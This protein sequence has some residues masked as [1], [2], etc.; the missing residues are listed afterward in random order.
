MGRS[1]GLEQLLG[2]LLLPAVLAAT[3]SNTSPEPG[4]GRE[5]RGGPRGASETFVIAQGGHETGLPDLFGTETELGLSDETQVE[6]EPTASPPPAYVQKEVAKN[7]TA[8]ISDLDKERA[9]LHERRVRRKHKQS[10]ITATIAA[11]LKQMSA[12]EKNAN[13]TAAGENKKLEEEPLTTQNDTNTSKVNASDDKNPTAEDV[14]DKEK[15]KESKEQ[16]KE[17]PEE[18]PLSTQNDTNTDNSKD[19]DAEASS[20]TV[21]PTDTPSYGSV[22]WQNLQPK[23]SDI[24]DRMIASRMKQIAAFNPWKHKTLKVNVAPDEDGPQTDNEIEN[25]GLPK[26]ALQKQEKLFGIEATK[27]VISQKL[28]SWMSEDAMKTMDEEVKRVQKAVD[29]TTTKAVN[30]VMDYDR[31]TPRPYGTKK[32]RIMAAA[33]IGS[34]F[35]KHVKKATAKA[36]RIAKEA[37]AVQEELKEEAARVLK[38]AKLDATSIKAKARVEAMDLSPEIEKQAVAKIDESRADNGGTGGSNKFRGSAAA[39]VHHVNQETQLLRK[40]AI[41]DKK[42][43]LPEG[44]S[45]IDRAIDDAAAD[46]NIKTFTDSY[47][48]EVINPLLDGKDPVASKDINVN[49]DVSPLDVAK[50]ADHWLNG[51]DAVEMTRKKPA[52]MTAW[53][54]DKKDLNKRSEPKLKVEP[55]AEVRIL[56]SEDSLTAQ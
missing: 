52:M 21:D 6:S 36:R 25:S 18:E 30:K 45:R 14:T 26:I 37:P 40:K 5:W 31:P 46:Q 23:K 55:A 11:D 51:V 9:A 41:E 29:F 28:S 35:S 56:S 10:K 3:A 39:L 32:E 53:Y 27:A 4:R 50:E 42:Q 34:A 2:L 49:V 54:D 47:E 33:A 20:N 15:P 44:K 43:G 1:H 22:A 17:E 48:R 16:P 12:G 13:I 24:Q 19:A 7:V 38:Q 8:K